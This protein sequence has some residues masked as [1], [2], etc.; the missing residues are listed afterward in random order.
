[1][2]GPLHRRG[3]L[4]LLCAALSLCCV[5]AGGWRLVRFVDGLRGRTTAP[6]KVL[7]L[8]ASQ[9]VKLTREGRYLVSIRCSPRT[10]L[11]ATPSYRLTSAWSG[12][13]VTPQPVTQRDLRL[14]HVITYAHV[15]IFHVP[16]SGLF[17]LSIGP[18]EADR[19]YSGCDVVIDQPS[20]IIASIV[21]E[22]AVFTGAF[23]LSGIFLA[24][25]VWLR[26]RSRR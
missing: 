23:L 14:T 24:A 6:E 18:L 26:P 21:H 12:Y 8:R 17:T 3:L 25:T 16:Q 10:P 22:T 20:M 4:A 1:M 19:D 9:P 13:E 11:T 5:L 15:A 7:P 2:S